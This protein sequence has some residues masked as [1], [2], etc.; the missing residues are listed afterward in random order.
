[1]PGYDSF[2]E[3]VTGY[4]ASELHATE[5]P[6]RLYAKWLSL[7]SYFTAE[8]YKDYYHHAARTRL[9]PWYP[10]LGKDKEEELKATQEMAKKTRGF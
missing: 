4:K 2:V 10:L 8:K 9:K 5:E 1:M 7:Q 3:Q 6:S